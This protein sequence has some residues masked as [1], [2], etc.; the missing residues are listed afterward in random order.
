MTLI[1]H[2]GQSSWRDGQSGEV[3]TYGTSATHVESSM[4]FSAGFERVQYSVYQLHSKKKQPILWHN[5]QYYHLQP[6]HSA[7]GE[8]KTVGRLEVTCLCF[9]ETRVMFSNSALVGVFDECIC[10]T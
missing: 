6:W 10:T 4:P 2:G 7:T 1:L 3:R 8:L 5:I 9:T